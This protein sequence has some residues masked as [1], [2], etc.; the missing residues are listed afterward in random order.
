MRSTRNDH[1]AKVSRL[2][3]FIGR[4]GLN[5]EAASKLGSMDANEQD[6]VIAKRSVEAIC[7]SDL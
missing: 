5:G 7:G 2:D 1:D 3:A 4:W 6:K